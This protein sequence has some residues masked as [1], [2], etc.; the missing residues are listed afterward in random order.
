MDHLVQKARNETRG[1]RR[2]IHFNNAG[3]ALMP[4]AVSEVLHNYL[5]EE[6][7]NGG[8]ETAGREAAAL[9]DFYAAAAQLLNCRSEEIAFVDSA[10]RAWEMA[11]HAFC[12]EPGDRILT[13]ESEYPSNIIAYLQ[14]AEQC[15][16]ELVVVPDDG[17]GQVDTRVLRELID[18]RTKLISLNHVPTCNGL[19]NPVAEIGRIASDAGIP[20]L[21]DA[22][23]SI[24]QLSLD[25][26]A[27]ACDVLCGSGRKYLRGPRGTA[28]LYVRRGLLERMQPPFVDQHTA[29]LLPPGRFT[30]RDDARRFETWENYCAGKAALGAAIRYALAWGID[31]IQ[32]RVYRLADGLRVRLASIDGVNVTDRGQEQCGIVTFEAAQMSPQEIKAT[33][34]REGINV[35]TFSGFARFSDLRNGRITEIVRASLHYYNSDEELDTF[36][37]KLRACLKSS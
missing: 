31:E 22:S 36:T 6:E 16:V 30:L 25:V 33:L 21:L 20:F 32:H 9:N 15:G 3:A 10:T 27:L 2:I 13:A 11:F 14:Q 19:V 5:T 7:F 37:E 8:Y 18:H 34:A 23:Q 17:Y 28:L 24:G 1:C 26:D 29:R 35:S 12:F 4:V